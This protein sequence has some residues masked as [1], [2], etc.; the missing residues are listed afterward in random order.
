MFEIENNLK[1]LEKQARRT[2]KYFALKDKYKDLSVQLAVI[3]SKDYKDA[4]DKLKGSISSQQ[5]KLVNLE[6]KMHQIEAD[7]EASKKGALDQERL[8]TEGQQQLHDF[9]SNLRHLESEKK[10]KNQK[11]DFIQES[12]KQ[13][14]FQLSSAKENKSNLIIQLEKQKTLL[15]KLEK[16]RGALQFY[17]H[18]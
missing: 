6:R 16:K 7:T 9:T 10:I 11:I 13:L 17:W 3:Q 18:Q 14:D 4:Y 2:K 15:L 8:V 5:D 1:S 12:S